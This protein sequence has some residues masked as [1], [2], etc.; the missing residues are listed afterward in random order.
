M[1]LAAIMNKHGI[2]EAARLLSAAAERVNAESISIKE[3]GFLLFHEAEKKKN[4]RDAVLFNA[5]VSVW[6]ELNDKARTY[7]AS[8][9]VVQQKFNFTEGEN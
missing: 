8:A 2:E 5:L 6:S 1:R 4:T 3:L 9:A 7:A